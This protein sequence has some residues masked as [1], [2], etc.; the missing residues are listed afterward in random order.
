MAVAVFAPD[1]PPAA[2]P[3]PVLSLRVQPPAFIELLNP[4]SHIAQGGSIVVDRERVVITMMVITVITEAGELAG[5]SPCGTYEP[6]GA[7]HLDRP[8]DPR[9]GPGL[10][11]LGSAGA[12]CSTGLPGVRGYPPAPPPCSPFVRQ[13]APRSTGINRRQSAWRCGIRS[14]RACFLDVVRLIRGPV[15]RLPMGHVSPVPQSVPQ[16]DTHA[17]SS[18]SKARVA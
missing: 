8:G 17:P 13:S 4:L 1:H 5:A 9:S 16:S 15:S 11:W 7:V 3:V 14:C 12:R 18:S 6:A 10:R 2:T